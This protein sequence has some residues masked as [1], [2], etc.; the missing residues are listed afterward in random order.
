MSGG[1]PAS[2][3]DKQWLALSPGE[4]A[5]MLGTTGAEF[6]GYCGELYS[7]MDLKYSLIEGR[8]RDRVIVEVLKRLD[9]GALTHSGQERLPHWEKGWGEALDKFTVELNDRALIPAY[10]RPHGILRINGNYARSADSNFELNFYTLLRTALFKKYLSGVDS[11]YEFGCG[12]GYNLVML[13]RMY[14][15]KS[16]YGLDW[17]T[18]SVQLVDSIAA[19]YKYRLAGVHFDMYNPDNSLSMPPGSA[20]LTL[21]SMEQLG[22]KWEAFLNFIL[23]K[24]PSIC[25][26]AEPFEEL[27]NEGSLFD[28]LALKYHRSRGYL[29]G[30]LTKLRELEA[31]G[32]IEILTVKRV[33]FGSHFH[34]GYSIVVWRPRARGILNA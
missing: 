14:P 22:V 30:F 3:A 31:G 15:E 13:A 5:S 26:H 20:L 12:T 27:Y 8:E 21:N 10:V 9:S 17:A 18:T 24:G 29:S 16:L 6:T 19:Q 2:K 4:T 34:E 23:L 32:R 1:D 11:I 7:G 25:V 33:P 28:Y